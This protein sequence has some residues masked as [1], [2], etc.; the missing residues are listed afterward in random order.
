MK[1]L[2]LLFWGAIGCIIAFSQDRV[3]IALPVTTAADETAD[4]WYLGLA[5]TSGVGIQEGQTFIIK[6]RYQSNENEDTVQ[7]AVGIVKKIFDSEVSALI[8]PGK[9]F[10]PVNGGELAYFM[11][12]K[13][14][15][16]KDAFYKLARYHIHFTSVTDS[17]IF[18]PF[19]HLLHFEYNTEQTIVQSLLADIHYTGKAMLEQSDGQQQTIA[20]GDFDGKPLFET[21]QN[22]TKEDLYNFLKYVWA[23][24]SKYAGNTW[25]ISEVFATW[26]VSQTP[27]L[28]GELIE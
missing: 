28:I 16:R 15:S 8:P 11:I 3:V 20:G 6:G 14:P 4:G 13:D 17:L 25:K 24:P 22:V 27:K 18:S 19:D 2:F 26:M 23:R 7:R 9:L 10:A 21:M 1:K 5:T 12:P